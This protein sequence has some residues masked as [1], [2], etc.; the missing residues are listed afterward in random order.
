[1][2]SSKSVRTAR[3]LPGRSARRAFTLVEAIVVIVI[4]GILSAIVA[5]RL[6][7]RIGH[8]KTAKAQADMAALRTGVTNIM[9]D[10]LVLES[11]MT[12]R[13]ILWEK[14]DNAP[15]NWSK[16]INKEADLK[17]P[18]GNDYVLVVPGKVN[19]DFDIVSYGS[20]GRV[21]GEGDAA[22]ITG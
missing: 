21:G 14:P 7:D 2:G 1:M 4:I 16:Q 11:G 10:G 22:D 18:W 3:R 8:A 15:A 6:I 5:P 9:L 12:L 17:D 19:T 20:D 13:N